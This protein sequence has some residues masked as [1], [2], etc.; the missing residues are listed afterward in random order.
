LAYFSIIDSLYLPNFLLCPGSKSESAS[1]NS[2]EK[3]QAGTEEEGEE[4]SDDDGIDKGPSILSLDQSAIT[5]ESLA[6]DKCMN[7]P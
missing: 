1:S 5:G 4:D 6:V 2:D 7:I 3:K